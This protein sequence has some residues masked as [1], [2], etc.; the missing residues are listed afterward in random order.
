MSDSYLQVQCGHCGVW[1]AGP[2]TRLVLGSDAIESWQVT[3]ITCP[4]CKRLNVFL[5]HGTMAILAHAAEKE[6]SAF[7]ATVGRFKG[8]AI[9]IA[10]SLNYRPRARRSSHNVYFPR[11]CP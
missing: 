9:D 3:T 11:L 6:Q 8:M 7:E 10:T 5:E 1:A 4:A 2:C